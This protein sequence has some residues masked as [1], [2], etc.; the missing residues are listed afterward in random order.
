MVL[1]SIAGVAL[2]YEL[3]Q[4]AHHHELAERLQ[5]PSDVWIAAGVFFL[6]GWMLTFAIPRVI[7]WFALFV[8]VGGWATGSLAAYSNQ[9][10]FAVPLLGL[11]LAGG[12]VAVVAF[13]S[14]S[15]V[16]PP[17]AA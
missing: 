1:G 3:V 5:S 14:E 10:S 17:R 4:T 6:I 2:L 9:A 12:A 15:R 13:H 7:G 11:G 8:M 16:R